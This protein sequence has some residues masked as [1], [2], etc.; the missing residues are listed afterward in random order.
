MFATAACY[1]N[2]VNPEA[3]ALMPDFDED[4]AWL[5]ATSKER[6]LTVVLPEGGGEPYFEVEL[7]QERFN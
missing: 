6:G 2:S 1:L 7:L 4:N 5:L 3:C